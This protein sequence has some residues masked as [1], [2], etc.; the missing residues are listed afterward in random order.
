MVSPQTPCLRLRMYVQVCAEE[1][2]VGGGTVGRF[3]RIFEMKKDG[4]GKGE[5]PNVGKERVIEGDG[6]VFEHSM[7]AD[8][9]SVHVIVS[10]CVCDHLCV[11]DSVYMRLYLC[12]RDCGC[13]C[14][15]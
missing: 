11:Y 8:F 3:A 4:W 9:I 10:L 1:V 6:E 13:T 14:M 5:K 2:C 7:H 15:Y 12:T